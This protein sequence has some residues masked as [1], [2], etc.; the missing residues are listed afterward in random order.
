MDSFIKQKLL[1]IYPDKVVVSLHDKSSS[2]YALV[3]G[4]AREKGLSVKDYL[5][6]LGFEQ[7]R[8]Q[9]SKSPEKVKLRNEKLLSK[10]ES[11]LVEQFPDKVIV[12]LSDISIETNN[13]LLKFCREEDIKRSD[14]VARIGFTVGTQGG[15]YDIAAMKRLH[16]EFSC[17]QATM[18]R[19]LGVTREAIRKKVTN[20]T[21]ST[22]NWI[23]EDLDEE[24]YR[25]FFDLLEQREFTYEDDSSVFYIFN[26]M[27]DKVA[28]FYKRDDVIKVLFD[29]PEKI[30][31]A[32]SSKGYNQYT[33]EE[34]QL[35]EALKEHLVYENYTRVKDNDLQ[36]KIRSV[37]SRR[38]MSVAEFTEFLGYRRLH[39]NK[40]TKTELKET[41]KKYVVEGNMVHIP[42][43]DPLHYNM[44]NRASRSG[45]PSLEAFVRSF[46][47]DYTSYYK[48]YMYQRNLDGFK[49]EM[50]K[51]LVN[52]NS[53]YIKSYD[54][55]YVRLY[56][57]AFKRGLKID[58]VIGDLGFNRLLPHQLPGGF[59]PYD[60]R[61]DFKVNVGEETEEKYIEILKQYVIEEGSNK[62][63]I[64]TEDPLYSRL[65]DLSVKKNMSLNELLQNW[66]YERYYRPQ[67]D[68]SL[69]PYDWRKDME[70]DDN[71][72]ESADTPMDREDRLE[73]LKNIQ[74]MLEVAE[75]TE[76]RIKRS[77]T[78]ANELK[79]L[80]GHK[81][82]AC[83]YEGNHI[84]LIDMGNGKFYTEVHHIRKISEWLE[85]TE[86]EDNLDS[87]LNVTCLCAHHHKV[88]HYADGGYEELCYDQEN[89]LHFRSKNGAVLK[90]VTN[91]HLQV[92]GMT[93]T[94]EVPDEILVLEEELEDWGEEMYEAWAETNK[95]TLI[96]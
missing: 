89:G 12:R 45:Y 28:I 3:N 58:E 86:E 91:Y 27:N 85:M 71:D 33:K 4:K 54:P 16:D 5:V 35:I 38:D 80:Y 40:I 10:I 43:D 25:L 34:L 68:P 57:F 67:L 39:P 24:G 96:K 47:F 83:D 82:Q 60:W 32:L 41:L 59:I 93:E 53:V 14:L 74:T 78:L 88:V 46:G 11:L 9:A 21:R 92:E 87:Y 18:A 73:K 31:E 56:T 72:D 44:A 51:Y 77:R 6:S 70:Q 2:L 50:K 49:Q 8:R 42:C 79:L 30:N 17:N 63:Y 13:L 61:K 55:L 26:D 19:W 69:A 84:P 81:C 64:H 1:N 66:G 62:V 94:L 76:L 23:V 75:V 7:R 36:S 37:A 52:G 20:N 22:A 48:E 90:V 29:M 65:Y 15:R 95:P